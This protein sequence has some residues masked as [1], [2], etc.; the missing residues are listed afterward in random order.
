MVTVIVT[1]LIPLTHVAA[2][3]LVT[4]VFPFLMTT[5]ASES[6]AVAVM[7]FVAVAVVAVYSVTPALKVGDNVSEPKLNALSAVKLKSGVYTLSRKAA[8]F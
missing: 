1:V 5:V 7:V 8:A 3:P 2:E 4:V 6:A